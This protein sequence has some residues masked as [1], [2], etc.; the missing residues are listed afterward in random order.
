MQR[1]RGDI[2]RHTNVI[3]REGAADHRL[4]VS[5]SPVAADDQLG[6]ALSLLVY[7]TDRVGLLSVRVG[8]VG[9]ASAMNVETSIRRRRSERV[10]TCTVD[11]LDAVETALPVALF[12]WGQGLCV[13]GRVATVPREGGSSRYRGSRSAPRRAPLAVGLGFY[14]RALQA[15]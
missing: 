9:F 2:H 1:R 10:H 3:Q 6:T 15:W 14:C 13:P 8:E 11:E 7:A 4:I 12:D 5:S